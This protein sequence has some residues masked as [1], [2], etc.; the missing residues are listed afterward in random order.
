MRNCTDGYPSCR[1]AE[2][3]G[4]WCDDECR[5]DLQKELDALILKREQIREKQM[6][7]VHNGSVT[8][9]R[10]TGNADADRINDRIVEIRERMCLKNR[11]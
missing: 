9:A 10:T 1:H 8:R 4:K 2:A 7:R 5:A 6:A 11:S 3:T